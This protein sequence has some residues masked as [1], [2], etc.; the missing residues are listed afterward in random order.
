MIVWV[1]VEN[2]STDMG[3]KRPY[4]SLGLKSLNAFFP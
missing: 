3:K 4:N 2:A 1:S